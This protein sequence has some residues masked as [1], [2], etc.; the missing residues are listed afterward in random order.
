MPIKQ[1]EPRSSRDEKY[2]TFVTDRLTLLYPFLQRPRDFEGDEKFHYDTQALAE[3]EIAA[4]LEKFIDEQIEE[5]CRQ[6]KTKK[7]AAPPYFEHVDE[8]E[9]PTGKTCFKFKVSATVK[10]KKGEWDR[11][12]RIFDAVGNLLR[13]DSVLLG[14]GT[15]AQIS[16][17]VYHWKNKDG[18][19]VSLQPKAVRVLKLVE[20]EGQSDK[21]DSY[22]FEGGADEGF[23]GFGGGDADDRLESDE[24]GDF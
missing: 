16:F 2:P 5:S 1:K 17:Q 24:D 23:S 8:D 4:E 15:E 20:F 22:G 14:T 18:A 19:G 10:T 12:P 21:A 11:K 7:K 6:H 3:G 9:N 13:D